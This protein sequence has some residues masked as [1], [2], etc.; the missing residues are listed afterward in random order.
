MDFSSETLN[1]ILFLPGFYILIKSA[2]LLVEGS[3]ALARKLKISDLVIGL[4]LVS[5]GTSA[6]ELAVNVISSIRGN[7]DLAISNILGSNIANILLI[8]GISSLIREL[9]VQEDTTWKEIPFSLL[10]SIAVFLLA[11]DVFFKANVVNFISRNEG[12]ILLCFFSIF[13][14]Y[15][16]TIARKDQENQQELVR[17][18]TKI[19]IAMIYVILGLIGLVLGGN[20]IVKGAVQIAH[21][22]GLSESFIGLTI[23]AVG[24]SL[25]ELATS[26]VAA[27]KNNSEIAVGNVVGSNIFNVFFILGVS[28]V[29]KPLPFSLESQ[30][31]IFGSLFSSIIL[32]FFMFVGK[33][34]RLERN[35][36]AIF[37]IIYF[38]YIVYRF[39][40][41]G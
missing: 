18:E 6:P 22:F 32:F 39:T 11:N 2:D 31:D 23:V 13:L 8:L 5:F 19:F 29:I 35:Q 10:G 33:R 15:V 14:Y 21:F 34:H 20:W 37:L 16:Y 24:T 28:A 1:Y 26:A 17:I 7:T 4:T 9:V 38:S 30:I 40:F 36:G 3:V 25:P 41:G 12:Y 27:Y